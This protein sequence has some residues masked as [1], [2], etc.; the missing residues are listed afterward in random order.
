M[1]A[2]T[3]MLAAA[4]LLLA[5]CG[6]DRDAPGAT[7]RAD[8]VGS[9]S[10]PR[11]PPRAALLEATQLGL[12]AFDNAGQVIPGLAASWRVTAD[13]RSI[14]FRLRPAVWADGRPVVASD[15]VAVFRRT[16]APAS[17][18]ALKP[19]LRII[20]NGPEVMAGKLP[21]NA[22]EVR[23]PLPNT[24]V[25]GLSAPAPEL[26]PLLALPELAIVRAGPKPP[27]LGPFALADAATR[28]LKLAPNARYFAPANVP[29][30][31]I[32]LLP[33]DEPVAA[34]ARFT[35]DATDL[36]TGGGIAGLGD[37]RTLPSPR[38]LRLE[39]AWGVYGYVV[40]VRRGPLADTGVRRALAMAIDRDAITARL[41]G[42]R[43]IAPVTGVVPP[44]LAS[45]PQPVEPAWVALP[46]AERRA[47]AV[48]LLA[49]AGWGTVRP[50]NLV[51]SLPPGRE[52]LAVLAAVA[53]DLAP[54]GVN[55]TTVVHAEPGF[56]A[57]VARGD[58]ELALVERTAPVDTPLFFLN[59]FE[60]G[61]SAG[62][63]C[64]PPADA[65]IAA[66][67]TM[68]EA[69]A[70]ATTLRQAE[71]IM[72]A[73]TPLIALFTP[74]RWSL[75]SSRVTGWVDNIAG[76]HPLARL[77]MVRERKILR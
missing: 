59:P 3:F 65:L 74:V 69:S 77:D 42:V 43:G 45:A 26:L 70:R 54:L 4:A 46:F 76:Q 61:W 31:G 29:L 39:P 36:V 2:R 49:A 75:V 8:V 60:C 57:S 30:G 21:V 67:R 27:A 7:L 16:V 32:A 38:L 48:Q 19:M 66:A 73:D 62:G 41:F 28:P 23:A 24:V 25:I 22:L 55:L 52:H 12:V 35:R 13:G 34:M 17:R 14:V 15:V 63:Y 11:A 6:G 51:V 68:P 33:Q 58:F 9:S 64:A 47:Q 10:D 56:A 50:L 53:A 40:N 71:A 18:N 37:A 1:S 72:V 5:A 44:G 20:E